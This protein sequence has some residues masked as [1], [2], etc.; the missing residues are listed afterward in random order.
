MVK[1]VKKRFEGTQLQ[2]NALFDSIDV[3]KIINLN[4]CLCINEAEIQLQKVSLRLA[5]RKRFSSQT[6]TR[7]LLRLSGGKGQ[8]WEA[9]AFRPSASSVSSR[10][11]SIPYTPTRRSLLPSTPVNLVSSFRLCFPSPFLFSLSLVVHPPGFLLLSN[12]AF[13]FSA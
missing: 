13:S 9:Y 1:T 5:G 8:A 7:P 10:L 6:A 2:K 11:A 3:A 12:S 4:Q